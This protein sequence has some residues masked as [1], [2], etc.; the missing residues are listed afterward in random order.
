[1]ISDNKVV[2]Y[3]LYAIGEIFLVVVGILIAFQLDNWN[4]ERQGQNRKTALLHSLKNEFTQNL[5][6]LADVLHYDSLVVVSSYEAYNLSTDDSLI[7]NKKYM[8]E[9]LQNTSWTW[10]FDAQNGALRS[11]ISSGDINYIKNDTLLNYLFSWQDVVLDAKEN[12]VYALNTRLNAYRIMEKY[13][14]YTSFRSADRK[15]FHG[16][17]FPSDYKG[18]FNDPLFEDY[19]TE[20]YNNML[21]AVEEL[22]IV[23][24]LNINILRLIDKELEKN[25]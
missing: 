24:D 6:Q 17:K 1:M 16:S 20:R 15:D 19:I 12:E 2:K 8:D 7:S 10:T 4:T 25:E 11:G 21:E 14:R 22:N 23:R 5:N 3:I 13:V 9:L 18:L